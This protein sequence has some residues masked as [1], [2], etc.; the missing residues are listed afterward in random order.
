[1]TLIESVR[2]F[3]LLYPGLRVTRS[4]PPLGLKDAIP[5]R[6]EGF[7]GDKGCRGLSE[8][9]SGLVMNSDFWS[10]EAVKFKPVKRVP[11][12]IALGVV[13]LVCTVRLLRFEF[14]ER[15][16]RITYD[17]RAREALEFSPPVATNLGFVFINESSIDFVR[18]NQHELGYTAGL[19]WPR[20]VYGRLVEEL[21]AQGAQGVALDIIFAELRPDH[22][23][24]IM[25]DAKLLESDDYFAI[26]MR[27]AANVVMAATGDKMPPGLFLTNA[28]A[29]GDISIEKDRPE[30]ILRRSRA[31]REYQQWHPLFEQAQREY[32]FDLRDA[33]IEKSRIVLRRQKEELTVPLDREGNFDVTDF[34]GEKVPAGMAKKAKA[35]T[36]QRIWS[37]GIVLAA[38]A[39]E[40]DLERAEV[41]TPHGR[42]VLRGAQGQKRIIPIDKAGYFY[43]DWS[44]PPA[45][46]RLLKKPI[47]ELLV[48]N[49]QRLDRKTNDLSA[50]W[51]GRLVVVGSSAL[52]ND[53]TDRGATPLSEDTLLVSKHW[54]VANSILTGRFVRRLPVPSELALI[55]L[56]GVTAA[57]LS[58][59]LRVLPATGLVILTGILYV[60]L[61]IWLYVQGRYW[62]PLVFPILGALLMNYVCIMSW[63]VIFEQAEVR[64]VKSIFAEVVSPKIMKELLRAKSL[65]LIGVRREVTVLFSDVRGFTQVTDTIQEEATEFVRRNNLSGHEAEACFDEHARETLATI[66]SYLGLVADIIIKHD[67]ILDKFIGDCVMAFWGAPTPNPRHAVSCVRAAI[68]AQRAIETLNQQ[69]GEQNRQR[70]IENEARSSAGLKPKPLLPLLLLGTGI[71]TGIVTAGLMGSQAKQKNYTVFGH[72]VNLASRLEGLSGHGHI[73]ISESTYAHLLGDD[74]EIAARCIA[75]PPA[76]IKG[77]RTAV[78]VYEVPWRRQEEQP[79]E[80]GVPAGS[81]EVAAGFSIS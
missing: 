20:H 14:F 61:S 65:S 2:D 12:V 47:Q 39:L 80:N 26:Q 81:V 70:E 55:A 79:T 77:I 38:K 67:G 24:I 78:N 34:V 11:A 35:F 6:T 30:G 64:R 74:P 5:F 62:I 36:T 4:S 37:M 50:A 21:A 8:R 48:E 56:L 32:G 76:E 18:T 7:M 25:T 69:R 46:P 45:D 1:M 9:E 52:G 75:Q 28:M 58:W 66:N 3:S 31:F 63:R 13:I 54:N 23:S 57:A 41:D 17:M 72:E 44:V 10:V 53:L 29:L 49:R 71:N 22:S 43:I 27:R 59:G 40:L 51:A 16:E 68:E 60:V 19:Y 33:R 15:L 42:I 73:F